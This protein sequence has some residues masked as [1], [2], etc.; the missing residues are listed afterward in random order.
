[1]NRQ[2]QIDGL[3]RHFKGNIYRVLGL[4]KHTETNETLV[5]YRC[6]DLI[7]SNG[8]EEYGDTYARPTEM[9][10]SEVDREKYP[11]AKQKYRFE[12]I[13]DFLREPMKPASKNVAQ[14]GLAPAT[15][16]F[17]LLEG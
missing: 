6:C 8:I 17:E 7:L 2:I 10:L 3:Y 15:E 12:L 14:S 5:I 13:T 4:A 11:D 9:F 16:N 1:M